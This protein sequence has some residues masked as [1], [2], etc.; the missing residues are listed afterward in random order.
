LGAVTSQPATLEPGDP[1]VSLPPLPLITCAPQKAL[2]GVGWGGCGA[3]GAWGPSPPRRQA[4]TKGWGTDRHQGVHQ[5]F[6]PRNRTGRRTAH[7]EA[8]PQASRGGRRNTQRQPELPRTRCERPSFTGRGSSLRGASARGYRGWGI[9][10][11]GWAHLPLTAASRRPLPL[12]G[13]VGGR[14]GERLAHVA[15][16]LGGGPAPLRGGGVRLLGDWGQKARESLG[17]TL[18][19]PSGGRLVGTWGGGLRAPSLPRL[20][21]SLPRPLWEALAGPAPAARERRTRAPGGVPPP[22]SAQGWP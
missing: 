8:G 20:C 3:P 7:R 18:G 13:C 1:G 11:H 14:A 9:T 17:R 16:P 15:P 5:H 19:C 10:R 22:G 6:P 12:S 21:P 2:E 4:G